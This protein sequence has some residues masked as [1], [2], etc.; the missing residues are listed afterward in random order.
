MT[1]K[2]LEMMSGTRRDALAMVVRAGLRGV[3]PF[4]TAAT[5]VRNLL[6]DRK[7]LATHALSRPVISI[8]N[9]TSGGTGKTPVVRWL[10]GALQER[11]W[12]VAILSRGYKARPGEAGDEQ[13]M[14][15]HMLETPGTPFPIIAAHP[16]RVMLG[17]SIIQQNPHVQ[18][19][20]LDDGFQHRRLR[21][22]LD[23]VLIDASS[24]F[25]FEHVLPRGLLRE[26]LSS[27]ARADALL[28]THA[29]HHDD[30]GRERLKNRLRHYNSRAPI[31]ES[32]HEPV[33][34][35]SAAVRSS[36]APDSPL[37]YLD[38]CR[39]FAFSGIGNPA[40]FE[41]ALR[42]AGA[43]LCG[44]RRFPDHY[45]YSASDL[46]GLQTAAVETGARAMITT[47]KDWV[48]LQPLAKTSDSELPILRLDVSLRFLD[49]GEA[50]L[51][52]L[53]I[54]A[55]SAGMSAAARAQ[56]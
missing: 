49:D 42:D 52:E 28:I 15:T 40:R 6:Y 38:G 5:V 44:V 55:I 25:G 43:L 50:R 35:R 14:L 10:A 31:F 24:P 32:I 13:I 37:D 45:D 27:L 56:S 39:I 47:E 53:A 26:P 46:E 9:I 23:V 21:R 16:N 3:E 8:G 22:D 12:Q 29:L 4:Y 33:G 17:R 11:G 54:A 30:A 41:Q 7:L 1:P 19:I 51:L 18:A 48:K 36:D 2:L 34:L 20:V